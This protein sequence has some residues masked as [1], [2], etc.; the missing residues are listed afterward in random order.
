MVL[1]YVQCHCCIDGDVAVL[2]LQWQVEEHAKQRSLSLQTW[3][4]FREEALPDQVII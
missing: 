3:F 4:A 2:K 1:P